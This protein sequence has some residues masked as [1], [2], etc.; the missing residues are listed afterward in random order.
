MLKKIIRQ[1]KLAAFAFAVI[2]LL[3]ICLL[4]FS[5]FGNKNSSEP[6]SKPSTNSL[7]MS[8]TESELIE[9]EDNSFKELVFDVTHSMKNNSSYFQ[10]TDFIE[11]ANE[12]KE[13]YK[14]APMVGQDG[15]ATKTSTGHRLY[16][17]ASNSAFIISGINPVEY[18]NGKIFGTDYLR[19]EDT[20]MRIRTFNNVSEVEYFLQSYASGQRILA[21]E[22]DADKG[23]VI[24]DGCFTNIRYVEK[25]GV[26]YFNIVDAQKQLVPSSAYIEGSGS[27]HVFPNEFITVQIPT[28][29]VTYQL[30]KS[31]SVVGG[32]FTFRSW[33]GE[34]FEYTVPVLN[35]N[36]MLIS[37][38]DASVMFGWKMYSNGKVLSIVSDELNVTDKAA[39]YSFDGNNGQIFKIELGKDEKFYINMYDSRGELITSNP[40]TGDATQQPVTNGSNSSSIIN[41]ESYSSESQSSPQD[42]KDDVAWDDGYSV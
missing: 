29:S 32:R 31:L 24:V 2:T 14:L 35:E 13:S 34:P 41:K 39:V 33:S 6:N 8:T 23:T 21:G 27:L 10:L 9:T 38:Q 20:G 28:D 3:L 1:N 4:A 19:E 17:G 37:V 30:K 7:P 22:T 26:M 25:N 15:S 5:I 36:D 18:V 42:S 11:W 40:Y 12:K 16:S